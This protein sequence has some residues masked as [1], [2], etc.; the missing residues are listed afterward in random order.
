[1]WKWRCKGKIGLHEIKTPSLNFR[2]LGLHKSKFT[3]KLGEQRYIRTPR[4]IAILLIRP[5]QN[6][7]VFISNFAQAPVLKLLKFR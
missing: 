6:T 5:Y 4:Q 2:K 3:G 7:R 1:M